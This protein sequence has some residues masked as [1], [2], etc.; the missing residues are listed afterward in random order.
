[1]FSAIH[2]QVWM[3]FLWDGLFQDSLNQIKSYS[4]A[5]GDVLR[6]ILGNK[7]FQNVA[8]TVYLDFLNGVN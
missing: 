6:L 8:Q 5:D 3:T 4:F 1:V 7:L 2:V